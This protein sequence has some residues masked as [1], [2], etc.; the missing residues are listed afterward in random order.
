MLAPGAAVACPSSDYMGATLSYSGA[1]LATPQ[2]LSATAAGMIPVSQCTNISGAVGHAEIAPDFTFFFSQMGNRGVVFD[3]QSDCDSTLIAHT[4][5]G[6]WHFNDDGGVGLMPRLTLGG[7]GVMGGPSPVEG[8]V[9]LWL[10]TYRA[11]DL[12]P[13]NLTVRASDS[14]IPQG[15]CPN[16]DGVGQVHRFFAGQLISPVR[17][18]SISAQGATE[19][20]SC[21]ITGTGF[22]DPN[23]DITLELSNMQDRILDLAFSGACDTTMLV[24]TADGQW[25]FDDDSNGNLDP[26][27]TLTE[28]RQ[29]EGRVNV[30]IGRYGQQACMGTLTLHARSLSGRPPPPPPD[31]GPLAGDW[32]LL[33]NGYGGSLSFRPAGNG[34]TGVLTLEGGPETLRDVRF[35]PHSGRIEFLRPIPGLEQHYVGT[36]R[37]GRIEGQFNQSGSAYA[38]LWTATR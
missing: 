35:D 14:A 18:N 15:G 3:V 32:R 28:T 37:D 36:L 22:V 29:M 23:P 7:A 1:Q 6:A 4:A 25:R 8:R 33:A 38:Y 2:V 19:L 34:W 11:N 30:W 10:G 24:R 16:P 17:L 9:D 21:G 27:L 31:S 13:A 20:R 12:C 5:D 26:R